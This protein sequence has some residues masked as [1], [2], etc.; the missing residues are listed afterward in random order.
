MRNFQPLDQVTV[1][2]ETETIQLG[3]READNE[4][5]LALHRE[6]PYVTISASFGPL[7]VALRPRYDELARALSKLPV[8]EGLHV[9]RQVGTS[10]A[11][12]A[13]GV[14]VDGTLLLRPT[15][16]ADA[17]GH[18]SLNLALTPESRKALYDWLKIPM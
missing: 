13:M 14:T 10:Q 4:P 15:I 17:T 12:L 6:G 18:M 2:A 3:Q 9:S 8:V 1:D 16:V 11:Y 7:E 5:I